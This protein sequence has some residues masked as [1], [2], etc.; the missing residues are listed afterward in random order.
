[1]FDEGDRKL[2]KQVS[3]VW[4]RVTVPAQGAANPSGSG[5]WVGQA[6]Q[7]AMNGPMGSMLKEIMTLLSSTAKVLIQPVKGAFKAAKA[8][9]YGEGYAPSNRAFQVPNYPTAP[10]AGNI[11]ER[12]LEKYSE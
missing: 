4:A 10:A 7:R 2:L 11:E 9:N 12:L 8:T 6:A 5:L 1:M 3:N